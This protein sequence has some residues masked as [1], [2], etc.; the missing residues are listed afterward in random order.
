MKGVSFD[1][2]ET[3]IWCDEARWADAVRRICSEVAD[4]H[5]TPGWVDSVSEKYISRCKSHWASH[6]GKVVKSQREFDG[7][8]HLVRDLARGPPR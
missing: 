2:D 8:R 1:L 6:E 3:L 5:V 4:A 7:H